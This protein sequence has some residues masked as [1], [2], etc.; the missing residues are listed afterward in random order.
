MEES[1]DD[2]QPKSRIIPDP[3]KILEQNENITIYEYP[4]IRFTKQENGNCKTIL[5]IGNS[6]DDLINI[7]INIL[8]NISFSDN[9]RYSIN[10]NNDDN[11]KIYDIY[12]NN[13][14]KFIIL[15]LFQFVMQIKLMIYSKKILLIYLEIKFQEIKFI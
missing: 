3:D 13:K 14:K 7:L 2:E 5:M 9:I 11:I 4:N 10:K 12:S 6:Q 8:C 15:R 1:E